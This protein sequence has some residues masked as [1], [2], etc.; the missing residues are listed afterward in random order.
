MIFIADYE[1][2]LEQVSLHGNRVD[3]NKKRSSRAAAPD[4]E[5]EVRTLCTLCNHLEVR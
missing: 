4:D 1:M 2:F 3:A 5:G